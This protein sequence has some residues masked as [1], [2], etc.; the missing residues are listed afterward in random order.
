MRFPPMTRASRPLDAPQIADARTESFAGIVAKA[1]CVEAH[2]GEHDNREEI[3]ALLYT[4]A[5]DIRDRSS[6]T[7]RNPASISRLPR[8]GGGLSGYT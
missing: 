7:P 5:K 1:R 2:I 6:L 3:V 8:R 4:I